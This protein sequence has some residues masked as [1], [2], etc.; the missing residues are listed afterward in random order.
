MIFDL[1]DAV[2]KKIILSNDEV[3][4]DIQILKIDK[5]NVMVIITANMYTCN[6][7]YPSS[8]RLY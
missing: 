6:F 8:N 7:F 3:T 1:I 2:Q 4:A 5:E